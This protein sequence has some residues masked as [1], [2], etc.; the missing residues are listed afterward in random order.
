MG[1]NTSSKDKYVCALNLGSSFSYSILLPRISVLHQ[2]TLWEDPLCVCVCVRERERDRE[3]ERGGIDLSF[4]HSTLLADVFF[5]LSSFIRSFYRFMCC[6]LGFC[7]GKLVLVWMINIVGIVFA[8]HVTK[9]FL[10]NISG[11]NLKSLISSILMW[12]MHKSPTIDL[13]QLFSNRLSFLL[14]SFVNVNDSFE[15]KAIGTFSAR[16]RVSFIIFE[17]SIPFHIFPLSLPSSWRNVFFFY[18]RWV[19]WCY[20]Y[21]QNDFVELNYVLLHSDVIIVIID[22]I[23]VFRIYLLTPFRSW[24]VNVLHWQF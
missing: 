13:K 1:I 23:A 17:R 7:L 21:P 24:L 8:Y 16:Y 12:F 5:V 22:Y 4:V 20:R 9:P 6:S 19:F 18:T 2:C 10:V 3:R 14:S 15:H 11:F